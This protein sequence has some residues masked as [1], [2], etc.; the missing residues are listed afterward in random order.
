MYS[1]SPTFFVDPLYYNENSVIISS[2]TIFI[3]S[4][5]FGKLIFK[6]TVTA[7]FVAII[8][9]W[10]YL[11]FFLFFFNNHNFNFVDSIT[12]LKGAI[13]LFENYS[14]LEILLNPN[15]IIMPI[16]GAHTIYY[17]WSY[18]SFFLFGPYIH[19]PITLNILTTFL[20][21]Y[22]L[23]KISKEFFNVSIKNSILLSVIYCLHW[24]VIPWSS[25][26]NLR[27]ILIQVSI[28]SIIYYT[29]KIV[30]QFTLKN[31][32]M[33]FL[34]LFILRYLRT[35][36][37]YLFTLYLGVIIFCNSFFF[38]RNTFM[39]NPIKFTLFITVTLIISLYQFQTFLDLYQ[40]WSLT[41]NLNYGIK[42]FKLFL[43]PLPVPIIL[44]QGYGFLVFASVINFLAFPLII[45]GIV[46][47]F[48]DK[49]FFF[50]AFILLFFF[51]TTVIV[52]SGYENIQ[53]PR[54]R[55]M[56]MPLILFYC[57]YSLIFF[58]KFF[59]SAK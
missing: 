22:F 57:F 43:S 47:T 42:L 44:D 23:Y 15:K 20:G 17:Y 18:I 46:I 54:Q 37:A 10:V 8:K 30:N 3:F 14:F 58:P 32:I 26:F 16:S 1:I 38:K 25:F 53:G 19:S 50:N 52:I 40:S 48:K 55:L 12:Y 49:K 33:L 9:S 35:H 28:I 21:S 34:A 29:L 51:L 6:S 2:I 41:F 31:L 59:R 39:I 13:F 11:V 56:I 27:D 24:E 7:L 5:F 36:M 4:Y 45:L